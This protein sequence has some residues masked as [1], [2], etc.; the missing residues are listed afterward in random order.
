MEVVCAATEK[1]FRNNK[2]TQSKNS[3][4]L[5]GLGEALE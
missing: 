4:S 2:Y 3:P 5:E 1:I